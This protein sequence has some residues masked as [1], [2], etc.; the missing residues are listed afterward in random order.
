MAVFCLILTKQFLFGSTLMGFFVQ[1]QQAIQFHIYIIVSNG[2]AV[3]GMSKVVT[4]WKEY[5]KTT[6]NRSLH[7][8]GLKW[9]QHMQVLLQLL[10]V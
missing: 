10:L 2:D 1:L 8:I 6:Y 7:D 9:F 4:K 3:L 5:W